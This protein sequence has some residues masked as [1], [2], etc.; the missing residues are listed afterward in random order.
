MKSP[1]VLVMADGT[2]KI[3]DFGMTSGSSSAMSISKTHRG[4]GTPSYTAPELF[5]HLFVDSDD[6][7]DA[8]NAAVY[9]AACDVYSCAVLIWEIMTGEEPWA[10]EVLGW[11]GKGWDTDRVRRKLAKEVFKNQKRPSTPE[12]GRVIDPATLAVIESCWHQDATQR[13]IIGAAC[14]TGRHRS[15]A[16]KNA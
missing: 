10:A 14:S 15:A 2:C 5:T 9:T 7:D 8:C 12:D 11:A 3:A 6:D 16:G 4:G 1:N 13:S